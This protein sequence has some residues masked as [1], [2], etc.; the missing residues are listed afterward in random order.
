R[1]RTSSPAPASSASAAPV[2]A[3]AA[4]TC[5]EA[6][7]GQAYVCRA[8]DHACVAV[9]SRDCKAYYE[10]RDLLADDTVWLGTMFPMKGPQ[11]GDFGRMN[12][13]GVDLARAEI[14]QATSALDG[15]NAAADARRIAVVG[16]DDSEDAMRAA[17]HMVDD[18]GVP[19]IVG[20][21]SGQEVVDV[22]GGMLIRRG[23]LTVASLT[24]SPLVTRLP[25]PPDQPRLVW[26]TTYGFDAVA[27]ATAHLVH[28]AIEPMAPKGRTVRVALVKGS[29][30]S[31]VT[32]ADTLYRHLV[33]NA[34][35][36]LDNGRD[37]LELTTDADSPAEIAST[38][39]K[40]AA[41]QPSL[42]IS[43]PNPGTELALVSA[44]E[45]R[46]PA[47]S[48][49]VY[50]LANDETDVLAP[51]VGTDVDRRRRVFSITSRANSSANARFV[52]RYNQSKR[53]EVTRT[54]NPG[55][56]YDAFY[57]LAYAT[58]ALAPGEAA[59]GAALA[60]GFSRLVGPGKAIEVGP[61]GIFEA[62][63][64]LSSGGRVDLEGTQTLLDFDLSTGE[65]PWDFVLLCSNVDARG[66]ATGEDVESGVAYDAR[67]RRVVGALHC[68]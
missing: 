41:F 22:A 28:D 44:I 4:R 30:S 14:A 43:L 23:V 8:S 48:K 1:A 59:T 65:A 29:A 64:A 18:V 20:F 7:P 45:A 15:A 40:L 47:K 37:Y 2:P 58:F 36:A 39:D 50:V 10:P 60:R 24:P 49:P 31:G 42:V 19:A 25:Q 11:A 9:A 38:V 3:C 34:K 5:A 52:I 13:D 67:D 51:F 17:R 32:F 57:A 63:G 33:F 46:S 35:S 56:S 16:C 61:T 27:E 68:P 53:G 26:R 6:H 62:L 12:M 66:R 54:I 55:T 21:R